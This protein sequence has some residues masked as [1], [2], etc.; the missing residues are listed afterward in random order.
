MFIYK[1]LWKF[2]YMV[3]N[4]LECKIE[5]IE[6]LPKDEGFVIVANHQNSIDPLIL[7]CA[8]KKFTWKHFL[9]KKKKVYFIGAT[10]LKKR[11]FQYAFISITISI[12]QEKIGYLPADK[13]GLKRAIELLKEGNIIVIFPEGKRNP[14]QFL[15][16]GKKGAA[17]M[18]LKSRCKIVLAGCFG[19][20]TWTVWQFIQGLFKNKKVAFVPA[21]SL[22]LAIADKKGRFEQK[23]V[24]QAIDV[25][26]QALA[27]AC[28]KQYLMP[29]R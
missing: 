22:P 19:Y 9:P 23:I 13:Y 6:N 16:K 24:Q 4:L 2:V 11:I 26:M 10:R 18:A 14:S 15:A 29:Q 1:I 12:L 3:F 20:K 28:N 7:V 8:L 17:I 21:I 27:S 5:G 25:I